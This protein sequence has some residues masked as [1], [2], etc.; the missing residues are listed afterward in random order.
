MNLIAYSDHELDQVA[1][2]IVKS[3]SSSKSIH[4]S[5]SST[6]V[7]SRR[8]LQQGL[9]E[10]LLQ[11]SSQKTT[12]F[13]SKLNGG[14][15]VADYMPAIAQADDEPLISGFNTNVAGLDD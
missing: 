3:S 8:K 15:V 9:G 12:P 11:R 14:R 6:D 1:D 2:D 4:S 7:M 5:I 10:K 13:S